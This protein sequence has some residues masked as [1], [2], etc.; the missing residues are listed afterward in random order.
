MKTHCYIRIQKA[1][2]ANVGFRGNM[3][4]IETFFHSN[5]TAKYNSCM[6]YRERV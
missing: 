1:A 2:G 6:K 3:W 4:S 5:E